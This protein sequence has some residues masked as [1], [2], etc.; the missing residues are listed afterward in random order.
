VTQPLPE[1]RLSLCL[2]K[3]P[4]YQTIIVELLALPVGLTA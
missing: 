1:V 2:A 4:C 3:K